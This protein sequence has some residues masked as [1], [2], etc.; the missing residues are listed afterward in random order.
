MVWGTEKPSGSGN[1]YGMLVESRGNGHEQYS[2]ES[3]DERFQVVYCISV[4]VL[5]CCVHP[6]TNRFAAEIER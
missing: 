1:R 5:S 6:A 2:G 4:V 3:I